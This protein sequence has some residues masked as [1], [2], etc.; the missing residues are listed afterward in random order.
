MLRIQF[1]FQK[2]VN[3]DQPCFILNCF[4]FVLQILFLNFLVEGLCVTGLLGLPWPSAGDGG[5][6]L[7]DQGWET[8][9]RDFSGVQ[10][11]RVY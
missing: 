6:V 5:M 7:T 10:C 8:E 3:Y 2:P 9:D 1:L 11:H 4:T